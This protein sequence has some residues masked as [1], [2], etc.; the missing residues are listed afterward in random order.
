MIKRSIVLMLAVMIVASFAGIAYSE[1]GKE[2]KMSG[3]VSAVDTAAKSVTI[4]DDKG[5]ETVITGV[6]EKSLAGLKA[7]DGVEAAYHVKDGKNVAA[8][9]TKKAGGKKPAAP[10]Y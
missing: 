6:D 4:K 8:G 5:K 2:M 1:A 7:G 10:G 3:T 9:V